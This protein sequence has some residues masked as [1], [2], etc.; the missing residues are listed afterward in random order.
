[1]R[2]ARALRADGT[3]HPAALL[4]YTRALTPAPSACVAE[5]P[6]DGTSEWV[7]PP[8]EGVPA[9]LGAFYTD[10]SLLDAEWKLAGSVAR[11]GWAF[12]AVDEHGRRIA[13]AR[14]RPPAWTGGIHGTE[15]WALL[16]AAQSAIPGSSF[17]V[18]CRAV[19]MGAQR[20]PEWATAP[21]RK[22]ARAWG[23][24][25]TTLEEEAHRVVWMPAQ[26]TATQ[27]GSKRLGDGSMMTHRD[28]IMNEQ[29]D[30]LAKSAARA[31]SLPKAQRE[32]VRK[33]WNQVTAIAVW[34]GQATAL[35][36]HFPDPNSPPGGRQTHLRDSEGKQSLGSGRAKRGRKRKVPPA[37]SPADCGAPPSSDTAGSRRTRQRLAT[38]G[39][40]A[41]SAA[42]LSLLRRAKAVAREAGRARQENEGQVRRWLSSVSLTPSALPAASDRLAALRARVRAREAAASEVDPEG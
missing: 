31:D 10:G 23:P 25:T 6:Q 30:E 27:V 26:C 18:D 36:S 2:Q 37:M 15:L 40:A 11:R 41:P 13:A 39:R 14:G 20:G 19:Q 38:W 16:M 12:A 28:R 42:A 21:D 34:I 33:L 22:L 1:M 29:V 8:A 3:L 9:V 4:L 7:M 32:R 17:R 24:L 5:A 35:A